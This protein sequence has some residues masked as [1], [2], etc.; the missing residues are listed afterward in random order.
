MNNLQ[1]IECITGHRKILTLNAAIEP[2]RAG[3]YG[4][5]FAVASDNV[6]RLAKKTKKE[7]H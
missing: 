1:V 3:E 4:R 6:R 7:F 5:G 2:A